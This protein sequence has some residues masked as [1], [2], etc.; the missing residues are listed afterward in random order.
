M[1]RKE[2]KD[3]EEKL[4]AP[5]SCDA[6]PEVPCDRYIVGIGASAGGLEALE[7]FFDAVPEEPDVAFVVVQHLSPDF[8]SHMEELLARRTSLPVRRVTHQMP[9]EKNCIFLIPPAKTLT[10]SAGQFLLTQKDRSSLSFPIDT[11]FHS[12]AAEAQKSSIAIILSGTGSDGSRGIISISDAGGL[13]I[14]Q[15]EE[16]AKFD[17]MPVSAIETGVVDV[18]LEPED[19]PSTIKS[20]VE[21][22]LTPETLRDNL[23]PQLP[24][25]S[26]ATIFDALHERYSIDFSQYKP[27]TISRRIQR[28]VEM[29]A[30]GDLEEYA[31]RVARD[32]NEVEALY[33]DLLIGV[34]K[35]FRDA[36]AFETLAQKVVK[37]LVT[38]ANE[39]IRVW[40]P[41][42][43]SGEEAYTIAILFHEEFRRQEKKVDLKIFG[44]D[45]H[46]SSIRTASE[47]RYSRELMKSMPRDLIVRYFDRENDDYVVKQR[48]RSSIVFI[49]HNLMTAVPL[50]RL[51]LITCRNML[52]YLQPAAQRKI[53]TL[54]HFAL[55]AG[56]NL[57]LGPSESLGDRADEFTTL[58]SHWKIYQ[59]RREGNMLR[60]YDLAGSSPMLSPTTQDVRAKQNLSK[61]V[62]AG[63]WERALN[64]NELLRTYDHLLE[65]RMPPGF[66][67]DERFRLMHIFHGGEN[68][69]R[70]RHGS[71]SQSVLNLIDESL[72]S[73][74]SGALQHSAKED[75][76]V[77]YRGVPFIVNDEQKSY[78]LEVEPY[79][80]KMSGFRAFV[81]TFS[82]IREMV[83]RKA[84]P[85][86]GN[87][88]IEV[89]NHDQ[90]Q[91]LELELRFTR[92][93]LQATI[94]ELEASNEEL[95]ATNEELIASNEEL[96]SSNEELHS[97][98]E[99]LDTVNTEFQKKIEEL[100]L[101][102]D[103]TK[104]LL[105]A[106]D[107]GVIF[108]DDQYRLRKFT[109]QISDRFRIINSD[110]DQD[111]RRF[112]HAL[113]YP[114]FSSD[115]EAVRKNGRLREKE[116]KFPGNKTYL[117]RVAPYLSDN[118]AGGIVISLIDVTTVKTAEKKL[119]ALSK[120]IE[121]SNDAVVSFSYNGKIMSWN[122]GA[123]KLYGYSEEEAVGQSALDLIVQPERAAS[124]IADI[125]SAIDG[126]EQE[127]REVPRVR[128]DATTLTVSRRLSTTTPLE[129]GTQQVSSIERD[130]SEEVNLREERNRLAEVLQQTTDFV[131]ICDA[132]QKVVFANPAALKMCGYPPEKTEG[133]TVSSFHNEKALKF[134]EEVAIPAAVE[135]GVHACANVLQHVD[136]I[137]IPV[138]QVL[139]AHKNAQGKLTHVSTIMRDLSQQLAADETLA[140]TERS[141]RELAMTLSGVVNHFPEMLVVVDRELKILFSSPDAR[142][143][144][145]TYGGGDGALPLGLDMLAGKAIAEGKSYLPIDFT[146]V[147]EITLEDGT[148]RSY[149]LSVSVLSN[150]SGVTGAVITMQDVTEF[151]MLDD[152][153]SSLI[154]TV[155]HE[156]KNPV[157][158]VMMSLMLALEGS[159]GDLTE[160]Q[161]KVLDQALSH[162]KR[163]NGT[164]TSLLELTRFE[165]FGSEDYVTVDIDHLLQVNEELHGVTAKARGIEFIIEKEANLPVLKGD[166]NRVSM[167][168]DNLVSNAIKHSPEGGKVTLKVRR[169]DDDGI[170]FIVDDSGPGIPE[171][172]RE[173][174]FTRF[175][176][177]PGNEIGGSGLG[178]NLAKQFVEAHGGSISFENLEQGGCR[179][180]AEFPTG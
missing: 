2:E 63:S 76:A 130:I 44:S 90:R 144:I 73:S 156:L 10:V 151:R 112:D 104:N 149:L 9:I 46:P 145:Q 30:D 87:D 135:K 62:S 131:G 168:L 6:S 92:E 60:T 143:F 61:R 166:E 167:V 88:A 100:T 99:E 140:T 175:F 51:N 148:Q 24:A 79:T 136:G 157:A 20:Y 132:D 65:K 129:G 18:I 128:K 33:R 32:A 72:K 59:K 7:R 4:A 117:V 160:E 98:N 69:V 1:Q 113:N 26:L 22:N 141:N 55:R 111:I 31:M 34:T 94:E 97:V 43:A 67:V 127:V 162:T 16:S 106:T 89:L 82:E 23:P 109:P 121:N 119:N 64:E 8:E 114:G 138:T 37:P 42:C 107:V 178:L 163:V 105:T 93:N 47:G 11:F 169:S 146:G 108:L 153:K 177:V 154:G 161:K 122:R 17:G 134:I 180:T 25:R 95:Q 150:E 3:L 13:V 133:L 54:F 101:L 176:K 110:I 118:R 19:I 45:V 115:L 137:E 152:L 126:Q 83:P 80:D 103:D 142:A 14:S 56:G 164:I 120:L 39:Q 86:E 102:S 116:L 75:K 159:L 96:Q 57:M 70:I 49:E 158:V 21:K 5:Q 155:S 172:Y 147:R 52:I 170:A 58:D 123:E 53:F 174:I 139:V 27:N 171:E 68:F 78:D 124:F 35:F 28:R 50:T 40:V 165:E 85:E 91:E 71:V 66:L 81:I 179:F 29:N 77:S 12:L 41:G 36:D 173:E 15:S 84:D 74:L 48:L 38:N 125:E